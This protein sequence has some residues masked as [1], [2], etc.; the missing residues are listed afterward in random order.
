MTLSNISDLLPLV[1]SLLVSLAGLISAI[2]KVIKNKN[3]NIIKANVCEFM[4]QA[5]NMVGATGEQK[6]QAV[7]TWVEQFCKEAGY[8]FEPLQV[9]QAIEK[10]IDFSKRVNISS[11][12]E[13][14][15]DSS[16]PS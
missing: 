14:T 6:K 11:K 3:W 9:S 15:G 10:L 12:G 1:I 5:E 16:N 4:I 2:L 7:L 8:K 13:G